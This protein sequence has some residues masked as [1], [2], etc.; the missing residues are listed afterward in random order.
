MPHSLG[1]ELQPN[2]S[3]M[4]YIYPTLCVVPSGLST[5]PLAQR[6]IT[7]LLD[8]AVLKA[9]GLNVGLPG[10]VKVCFRCS[11]TN[12][13]TISTPRPSQQNFEY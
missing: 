8:D 4:K 3:L 7:D 13:T 9:I 6:P 5:P 11:Q 10:I 1:M 2:E 12:T